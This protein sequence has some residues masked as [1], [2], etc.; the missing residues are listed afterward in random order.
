MT[1]WSPFEAKTDHQQ[2][3]TGKC[4]AARVIEFRR[5]R[6]GRAAYIMESFNEELLAIDRL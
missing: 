4:S 2:H 3:R 1:E 6:H 5:W